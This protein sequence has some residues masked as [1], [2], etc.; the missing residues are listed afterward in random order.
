MKTGLA[1]HQRADDQQI[2]EIEDNARGEGRRIESGI[3]IDRA[4]KPAAGRHA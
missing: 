1:E 3:I 2:S 4:G